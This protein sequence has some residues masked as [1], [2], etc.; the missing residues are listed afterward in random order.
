MQLPH[1]SSWH[2]HPVLCEGYRQRCRGGPE[3]IAG[4]YGAAKATGRVSSGHKYTVQCVIG[5]AII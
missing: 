3:Y 1:R 4:A 5:R 2:V